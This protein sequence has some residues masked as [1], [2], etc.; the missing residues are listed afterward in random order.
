MGGAGAQRDNG[1]AFF[2][3]FQSHFQMFF[4][5]D[6]AAENAY[7]RFRAKKVAE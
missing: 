7:I 1:F 3:H 5:A 6:T 2:P 4:I